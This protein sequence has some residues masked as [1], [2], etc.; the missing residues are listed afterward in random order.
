MSHKKL[1]ASKPMHTM[2]ALIKNHNQSVSLELPTKPKNKYFISMIKGLQSCPL[3]YAF[4]ASP[5]IYEDWVK[6]FWA[7]AVQGLN[8]NAPYVAATIQGQAILVDEDIIRK[9]L[10]IN[11]HK[12]AFKGKLKKEDAYAFLDRM[13]HERSYPFT[14][15]LPPYWKFLVHVTTH[16]ISKLQGG[17][18]HL[19]PELFTLIYKLVNKEDFNYSQFIFESIYSHVKERKTPFLLYPRFIQLIINDQAKDLEKPAGEA[20]PMVVIGESEFDA[21]AIRKKAYSFTKP[22]VK[23]GQFAETEEDV[24]LNFGADRAGLD[25]ELVDESSDAEET[26]IEEEEDP[27]ET[28][29]G[30]SKV[31][32]KYKRKATDEPPVDGPSTLETSESPLKRK[33]LRKTVEL[34]ITEKMVEESQ[35]SK[36]ESS[37]FSPPPPKLA[38]DIIIHRIKN[39]E[40]EN[41][42][43]NDALGH[44]R[45]FI[46]K[47]KNSNE[48]QTQS[49]E[50]LK[51]A[52]EEQFENQSKR[53]EALELMK[54]QSDLVRMVESL[55][56]EMAEAKTKLAKTETDLAAANK[57]ITKL[58]GRHERKT[59]KLQLKNRKVRKLTKKNIK[60]LEK[61]EK[62]LGRKHKRQ[63]RSTKR[64]ADTLTKLASSI[65]TLSKSLIQE[66]N[67]DRTSD[68]EEDETAGVE[69]DNS[70]HDEDDN[71]SDHVDDDDPKVNTEVE[72]DE[73]N[74]EENGEENTSYGDGDN[75]DEIKN[76]SDNKDNDDDHGGG[77]VIVNLDALD[78]LDDWTLSGEDIGGEDNS[79]FFKHNDFDQLIG[80]PPSYK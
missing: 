77:G 69:I 32:Q 53:L 11:D 58:E 20:H 78:D 65:D 67:D 59:L 39:L 10:Q 42:N 40:K 5:I 52:N 22:L 49:L 36:P 73:V 44:I 47:Q 60:D 54:D 23:F 51:K 61:L 38:K 8:G 29:K 1:K 74:E 26:E 4:S 16:C 19:S 50:E 7:T 34:E 25:Y 62:C 63:A 71:D 14:D 57:K 37:K 76:D 3:S 45:T 75:N 43:K 41:V 9:T 24:D 27:E 21:M 46:I 48:M 15:A 56:K 72:D 6:E 30:K 70:S 18:D 35:K 28:D 64:F 55:E 31:S 66:E 12:D 13:S 79:I 33:R 68:E 2:N 17:F 80:K